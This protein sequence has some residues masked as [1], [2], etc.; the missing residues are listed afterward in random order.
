MH[1]RRPLR[2]ILGAVAV[3][4]L[5][6]RQTTDVIA[7]SQF[8]LRE[9]R[10]ADFA[11]DQMS[12]AGFAMRGLANGASSWVTGFNSVLKSNLDLKNGRLRVGI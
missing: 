4:P 3:L 12:G 11:P 8:A 5:A 1:D 9:R 6:D 7:L 2:K 10:L